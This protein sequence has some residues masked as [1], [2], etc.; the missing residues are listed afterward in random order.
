MNDTEWFKMASSVILTI[1]LGI[2]SSVSW[3]SKKYSS[4]N[5]RLVLLGMGN[6]VKYL[7]MWLRWVLP[8]EFYCK[9]VV[10]MPLSLSLTEYFCFLGT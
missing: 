4:A 7:F 6:K 10:N 9:F 2:H 1:N 8:C 3:R 5:I